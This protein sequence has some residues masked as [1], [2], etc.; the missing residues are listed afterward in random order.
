MGY[1]VV[2]TICLIVGG[3]LGL[4]V[5]GLCKSSTSADTKT[6]LILDRDYWRKEALKWCDK[7][8]KW[9]SCKEK[10][11]ERADNYLVTQQLIQYTNDDLV[12]G[13]LEFIVTE[14]FY[15]PAN[16]WWDD[17]DCE[18]GWSIIAWQPLPEACN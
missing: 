7:S 18:F 12:N 13:I 6:E 10:L 2:G 17:I 3:T 5:I 1:F 14:K 4:V 16:G 8:L 9:I 11:P 15:D